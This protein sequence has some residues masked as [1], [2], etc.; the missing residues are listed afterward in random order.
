MVHYH[1]SSNK[2]VLQTRD[3]F[4]NS[5]DNLNGRWER[6]VVHLVRDKLMKRLV[7]GRSIYFRQRQT[8]VRNLVDVRYTCQN[9]KTRSAV[10]VAQFA[11]ELTKHRLQDRHRHIAAHQDENVRAVVQQEHRSRVQPTREPTHS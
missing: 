7:F 1:H 4:I 5:P 2:F 6:L 10:V 8:C 9:E 11:I 3:N